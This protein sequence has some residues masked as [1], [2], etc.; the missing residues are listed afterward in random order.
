MK[1]S[2]T[3]NPSSSGS[4]SSSSSCIE[5]PLITKNEET[6]IPPKTKPKKRVRAKKSVNAAN[7]SSVTSPKSRSSIYRGVTRHR[8]TGRYEAHLWDKTTWNNVQNKRG[9][10]RAYDNEGDAARTYDLAA[11]KFWGPTCVLNFPLDTYTKE[12]EEM[13]K[14]TKEEYLASLRRRSSGFSRGVSK[15]RGVARHHHNGRWEARI[16]RVS[17]NKY[18]YLGTYNT[19]EEAAAAYD[20]AAIEFRGP[21]AVTNFDISNYADKLNKI[22]PEVQVKKEEVVQ[23]KHV[24]APDSFN[25][26]QEDEAHD[27]QQVE[28]QIQPSIPKLELTDSIDSQGMVVM[29]PEFFNNVQACEARDHQ[30]VENQVQP[31]IPKVESIDF[32]DS[33]AMVV[34]DPTEEHEHPWDLCLDTGF[35]SFSI[36]DIPLEKASEL[37]GLFDNNSFD[38]NIDFIFDESFMDTEVLLQDAMSG[39]GVCKPDVE[40]FEARDLK[41]KNESTSPSSSSLST[42]TSVCS[43]S[44]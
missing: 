34:M 40:N 41:G 11:L 37:L 28:N 22:V 21:N 29:E 2:C 12:C 5:S 42:L 19:Q 33:Q 16:G 7:D 1:K 9:R 32:M 6:K 35:N 13:E 44:I 25:K 43:S 31:N 17:G 24:M 14:L 10:Q 39:T 15:Y 27:H 38:E 20:M 26:V 18:L 36:P 23:V 30:Q 4:T 8:W 3:K